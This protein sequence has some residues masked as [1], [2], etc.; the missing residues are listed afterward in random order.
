MDEIDFY[1]TDE[2]INGTHNSCKN[3]IYPPT[4]KLALDLMCGNWGASKCTPRRWYDFM[5][6]V[7][8]DFVPFQINYKFRNSTARVDGFTAMN[9]PITHCNESVDVSR[10]SVMT[11]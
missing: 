7:E 5:G 1:I 3:V 2:Y 4:G 11:Q 10:Q 6:D 9:P 8:L